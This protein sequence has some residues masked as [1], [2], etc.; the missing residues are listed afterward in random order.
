MHSCM[1]SFSPASTPIMHSVTATITSNAH[2]EHIESDVTFWKTNTGSYDLTSS[3]ILVGLVN[4]VQK[5]NM[6]VS[7]TD[8]K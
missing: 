8:D 1:Q 6:I 4:I 5:T 2:C 3:D 7:G